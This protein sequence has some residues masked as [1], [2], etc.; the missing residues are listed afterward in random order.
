[1]AQ[2]TY[3]AKQAAKILGL[4]EKDVRAMCRNQQLQWVPRP[5]G[6]GYLI[7]KD[8]PIF[9]RTATGPSKNTSSLNVVS[10]RTSLGTD[11]RLKPGVFN[12]YVA[13]DC[14]NLVVI[15]RV[16]NVKTSLDIACADF[17]WFSI[18][19]DNKQEAFTDTLAWL[20]RKGIKIRLLLSS[21]R[22]KIEPILD[23][24][25]SSYS[26]FSYAICRRIHM[27]MMIFDNKEVYIGSANL[28]SAAMGDRSKSQTKDNNYEAG[29]FTNSSDIVSK[30]VEHFKTAWYADSCERCKVSDCPS[31]PGT[32][33]STPM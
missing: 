21:P 17:K 1:M 27:K 11:K 29:I 8:Q 26:S 18:L 32:I 3:T 28:T 13:D 25:M 5:S 31:R 15:E 23:D 30:A 9:N 14:H 22:G 20:A 19:R 12:L 16:I 6:N 33:I 2:D 4:E 7:L 10:G 24:L